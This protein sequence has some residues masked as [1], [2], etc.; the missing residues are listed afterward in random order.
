[1]WGSDEWEGY[2]ERAEME[3]SLQIKMRAAVRR[4]A[5]EEKILQGLV[6]GG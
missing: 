5:N 2:R 6:G 4:A 3:T 1:M